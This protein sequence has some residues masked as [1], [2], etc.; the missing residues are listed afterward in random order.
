MIGKTLSERMGCASLSPADAAE[1]V[2]RALADHAANVVHVRTQGPSMIACLVA[3]ADR[4]SVQLCRSIGFDVKHGATAVFGLQGHDAS[5]VFSG[6]AAHDKAWLE[7]P[8]MVHETKVLL[9]ARGA[10]ALV[11]LKTRGGEVSVTVGP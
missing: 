6:L 1:I 5:R 4:A 3:Q 11:S 2:Q 8:C 9:V 10:M 7:T